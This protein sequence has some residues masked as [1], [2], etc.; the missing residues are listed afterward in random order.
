[1]SRMKKP[2]RLESHMTTLELVDLGF[3]VAAIAFM[4]SRTPAA[5]YKQLGNAG[6]MKGGGILRRSPSLSN[7]LSTRY[8]ARIFAEPEWTMEILNIMAK[9]ATRS[10]APPPAG[11]TSVGSR[12]SVKKVVLP[13]V[14]IRRKRTT[15]GAS[16]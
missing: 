7:G 11:E 9:L 6:R 10:L 3:T 13:V 8:A 1:M 2:S 15:S 16:A 14:T 5:V 4:T 12:K